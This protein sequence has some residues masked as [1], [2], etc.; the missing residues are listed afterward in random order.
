MKW[1]FAILEIFLCIVPYFMM[2]NIQEYIVCV[3]K[4]LTF[5]DRMFTYI[6]ISLTK[7]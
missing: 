5:Y 7:Y 1:V 2:L 3:F 6:S 4:S